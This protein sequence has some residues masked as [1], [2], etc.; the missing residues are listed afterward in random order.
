MSRF[1]ASPKSRGYTLTSHQGQFFP[2]FILTIT[3]LITF[4]L[5]YSL[6]KPSK[7]MLPP[8]PLQL[9][10]GPYANEP[11]TGTDPE[12]TA[13]RIHS[14]FK[15][16]HVD[17]VEGQKR[18]QKRRERK[19]KRMIAVTVGYLLM[20]YMVYLIAVTAKTIPKIWDPYDILGISRVR[21][22]VRLTAK[23]VLLII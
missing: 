7:G 22:Q 17:L 9:Y 8:K 13:P 3:G 18:K 5:T 14:D 6:L 1:V 10:C 21:P 19:L 4:P 2:Y 12:N 16:P 11:R 20:G 15:P 23:V